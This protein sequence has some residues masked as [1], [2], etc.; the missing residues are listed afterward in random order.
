[1]TTATTPL[2]FP[3]VLAANN[4]EDLNAPHG[5][6][7][8]DLDW[9]HHVSLSNH[10]LRAAQTPPM[11]AETIRLQVDANA[12]IPLA[13][14][15]VLKALTDADA[16][17]TQP[18]FLYTP[19]G[20]IRK[21]DS[22]EALEEKMEAML[23]S[24]AERDDLFRLLSISQR[25]ELNS[26]SAIRTTRQRIDGDVFNTL[27][28]SIEFAQSLNARTMV[29]ELIKLPSLSTM[30]DAILNEVLSNFDHRQTRV[31]MSTWSSAGNQKTSQLT[32][33]M[34]LSEAVLAYFHSQG[35]PAGQDVDF[36]HPGITV[37]PQNK[38]QWESVLKVTASNLIPSLAHCIDAYWDA[39]GPFNTSRRRFLSQV[40]SDALQAT[41]LIKREKR[42]LTEAHAQELL[43]LYRPSRPDEPLLFIETLRLWEYEPLYVELAGSLMI[44]AK[45]HYLYTPSHGL[46]KVDNYLGFRDAL[47]NA[48]TGAGRKEEL[49]SLLSLEERNRFLRFDDPQVSGKAVT[50]PVFESL[51]DA[52]IGKQSKNLHFAM[53]MSRQGD[54]DVHALVD[55]A[56]DI[57]SLIGKNLLTQKTA[58]HW[59]TQPVFYG[60]L[61]PSNF[62]ADQLERKIKSYASVEEALNAELSR[63]PLSSDTSLRHALKG[64][65]PKLTNVFSLGIRAEAEL[66]ELNATLSP[67]ARDL[68]AAVFAFDAEYP[69]RTQRIGVKGFRP[70]VYSLRLACTE[71]GKTVSLPLANCFLLTERGGLDTPHSGLAILWTPADGLQVF[72]SVELATQQLNRHLL[73]SRK[74][75]G[76]LANLWPAQRKPH[77][78][79]QLDVFELIEDNVL[80]NRMKSF[81]ALFEAQYRYLSTLKSGD[82]Q[83]TGPE[84]VKSL[85]T[86]LEKAAPTNLTHA[87][88]IAQAIRLQQK[89]PAWLGAAPLE[90]Q[91]LQIDL[92]EQYR[93]SV[94]DDEDYLDGIEPLHT[95]VSKKLKALLDAR[96]AV[97]DLDPA[98][99]LITPNHALAGPASSLTEFALNHADFTQ[100]TGFR[101]S[102]TSGRALPDSLNETAVRQMLLSLDIPTAYKK[103]VLDEL[104][105]TS[106]DGQ[107]RK[108]RFRR[109]LPW[110]LL[111]HAHA[112]H[113]QQHLSP[114]G[115]DLIRQVLDMPDA[116]ARQAVDGASALI[117]PLELIKT[118]GAAA[119]KAVGLYL[120]GS[121]TDDTAP[122][123]LYS[124][125]HAGH[126]FTEFK[127]Q[128][129]LIAAFNTPGALQD[130][131][132]RRLPESQQAT[133]KNLF[134]AT[135]GSLSEITLASNPI[136][137]NL[138]DALFNDNTTLLSDMLSAQTE[139]NRQFDWETA[140]HLFS[141]GVKLVG[142]QLQGKLTFIETLW[143]SYQD[144][145]A[146]SE[147]LQQH[148][149]KAGLHD[150]IAGA[151]EMVSLG[152]LN[153]DDTF[154]LL[155]PIS[156]GTQNASMATPPRWKDIAST[157]PTRTNLRAFET[158]EV[159]LHNLQKN[160]IDGTYRAP[161][162]DK[163]YAPV[164]GMV[165]QVA[166]ANQVWR[167]VHEQGEG[168]ILRQSPD[169]QQWTV[170]PQRQT[171]RYGKVM[172]TLANS[173]SDYKASTSLNIEARGMA[174]IRRKYPAY[175]NMI[176]QA[177]EV[178]RYYSFNALHNLDQIKHQVPPGSRLDTFLKTFFGVR[179][180]DAS[181]IKKIHTAVS[182][183]CRALADPSWETR[184]AKR[185]VIGRLKYMDDRATAF[186]LEPE[187]AGRIY[188]TQYFFEVGLD[189][190]K[191]AVPDSFN[192]DAHAQAAVLIH[193]VSHQLFDTLDIVYLD[194]ALPFLDLISNATQFGHSKYNYQ[195]DQ[196]RNG[197]SL[198]TP[199]SKL[200]MGWD[201]AAGG[202]KS[203][204]LFP[205]HRDMAREILKMTGARSMSEARSIFLDPGS[206]TA[207]IDVILRNADSM[208]LL[209]CELGRQLDSPPLSPAA[210][211]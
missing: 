98:T 168:P 144:F 172:S 45:G 64:L 60:D 42:Q 155:D 197:L 85:G 108:Q 163:L 39:T 127:D 71:D 120:I 14:C 33:S 137:T 16:A 174:Q 32:R 133:F 209:I 9:L 73:D 65:L 195:K 154:G 66:R 27:V 34:T 184:N 159:S 68:I 18:A 150:F 102:S 37:S 15:L 2:L 175:A 103:I 69:D 178:A 35:R 97:K 185:L 75:S 139:K 131:L 22:P 91:R 38:R 182:P 208:T 124:P 104:S 202:L 7:Q 63:L 4:L 129:S 183:L 94:D 147:S 76:L 113:L 10:T 176:E 157:A 36:I 119:I 166:K 12:P 86:L 111:Q 143:E 99:L 79:Y 26:T 162:S 81:N 117:R 5:L 122:H 206:P 207:R 164:A 125:Y 80:L 48:P 149:W 140:L 30:L 17:Q 28:E 142:R 95:Y 62:M 23:D 84:R 188:L 134:A 90:E 87:T 13:G 105:T 116:I 3:E 151:A 1:M 126:N 179:T 205:E 180:V 114:T 11:S 210:T 78:R 189:W 93:S 25:A 193:E 132:I 211:F 109:Q 173:Y 77:G 160:R 135:V 204:E 67:A 8:A 121:S 123:V 24:P 153:R 191:D 194:A 156:P 110:Q 6:T 59:G 136:K 57:R 43:R 187:T 148:D 19:Y 50:W 118:R 141:A 21:F 196:Q 186:V 167:V 53:E 47:L 171:I 146:S 177:L 83:L 199:R 54:V 203:L 145:K 31:T 158:T 40:L 58:G 190:Y 138:F 44:S 192:V 52:I 51:A 198:T 181:L 56:L 61:R 152:F 74:R 128:A 89:L 107:K 165:F 49:Y 20:G 130:L 100:K 92:L 170:D 88:R 200:F 70:D 41:I 82:W 96:F 72:A 161:G 106:T 101:V 46:E 201:S 55:K 115:F 29:D 112:L 169:N